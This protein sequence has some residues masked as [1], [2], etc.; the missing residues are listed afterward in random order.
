MNNL[1]QMYV[2]L[3]YCVPYKTHTAQ[4]TVVSQTEGERKAQTSDPIP[5]QT[6]QLCID[7]SVC[8]LNMHPTPSST[9]LVTH[10]EGGIQTKEV[11]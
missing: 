7:G 8:V 11:G 5:L 4:Q 1:Q 2:L 9:D 6:L 10:G 3:S